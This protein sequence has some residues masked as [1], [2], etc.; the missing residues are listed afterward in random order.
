MARAS[1]HVPG[2]IASGRE[3][4]DVARYARE[5]GLTTPQ[6]SD[7]GARLLDPATNSTIEAHPITRADSRRIANGLEERSMLFFAVDGWAA[8]RNVSEVRD[9]DIT[10]IAGYTRDRDASAEVQSAAVREAANLAS[11]H[12]TAILSQGA[13]RHRWYVNFTRHGIDKGTGLRSWANL[14]GVSLDGVV[15]VG[16]SFNDVEA[17]AVAGLPV[18]MGSAPDE[19]RAAAAES[20]GDVDADGVA[21]AIERFVLPR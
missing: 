10:V 17:F 12:V 15:F 7:N 19:V 6:I 3:P 21:E 16:D 14:L 13:E 9:W 4:T 18:A 8:V 11:D 2:A 20:V 5:L 1:A